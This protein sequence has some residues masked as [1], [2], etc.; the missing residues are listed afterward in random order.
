VL[1]SNAIGCSPM[2]RAPP[3]NK[4]LPS[5]LAQVR[6][7]L[8]CLARASASEYV[9]QTRSCGLRTGAGNP[10]LSWD[11]NAKED[12]CQLLRSAHI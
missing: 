9:L 7:Y 8:L 4:A 11:R 3:P 6:R 5:L 12:L 1:D 10:M 2:L